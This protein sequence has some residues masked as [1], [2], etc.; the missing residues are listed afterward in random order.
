MQKTIRYLYLLILLIAGTRGYA[1]EESSSADSIVADKTKGLIVLPVVFTSPETSLGFGAAGFYYFKTGSSPALNTSNAQLIFIYTLEN[2][3]LIENPV[4]LFFSENK[5]WLDSEINYY[6]FPY[7][8][9]GI[10]SNI[11]L[12]QYDAYESRNWEVN[13][14]LSHRV[15]KKGYIGPRFSYLNYTD[16]QTEDS[17]Q[18]FTSDVIGYEPSKAVGFGV[19]YIYD[20]R[21]NVFSPSNG[22][23]FQSN[24][25][26]FSEAFGGDFQFVDLTIDYRQYFNIGEKGELALQV[27]HKS[28]I[29]GEIPFYSLAQLGGSRR[30]R[31]YFFGAYRDNNFS[32]FQAEYRR[33]LF[34]R[35]I[36]SAFASIGGVSENLFQYQRILPS[37][38]LGVRFE[39][40]KSEKIRVRADYG[41]GRNTTG[42]Y[43]N[44]NEAY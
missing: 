17:N 7:Q 1:Q 20:N 31:S 37:L 18:L 10:G 16:I 6:V 44:I 29:G 8:F 38:G 15:G 3:I 41:I 23:Y 25:F 34:W 43:L 36:G 19:G 32:T 5:Y 9:Y 14:A 26:L 27:Y 22:S 2:Q 42:F 12:D 30:M 28:V 4:T 39:L 13:L 24:L 33:Q 35:I 21:D 40:N 11:N